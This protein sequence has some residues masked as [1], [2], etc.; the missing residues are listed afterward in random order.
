[1]RAAQAKGPIRRDA[2][3]GFFHFGR[4]P[5]RAYPELHL[6]TGPR[7][8]RIADIAVYADVPKENIPSRPPL[9]TIEIISTDDSLSEIRRQC[10]E[11]RTWGVRHVWFVDP[12]SRT[13]SIYEDGI[14][15][16]AEFRLPEFDLVITPEL[17]FG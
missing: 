7:R 15:D 4:T 1:M 17:I 5:L 13:L 11:Y 3:S 9:I 6:R 2:G 12:Q 16:V 8:Y 10:K 14:C